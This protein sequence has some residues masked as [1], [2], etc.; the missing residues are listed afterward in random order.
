LWDPFLFKYRLIKE[1]SNSWLEMVPT[2]ER[3]SPLPE[4][5]GAR[6]A[7]GATQ[8]VIDAFTAYVY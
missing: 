1:S 4:P 3:V 7:E 6:R 5:S 2:I 8:P